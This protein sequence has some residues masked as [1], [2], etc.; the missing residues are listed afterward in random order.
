MDSLAKD[1]GVQ[2]S[3]LWLFFTDFLLFKR[4]FW[5]PVTAYQYRL[6]G[7]GKWEGARRAIFTQFDRM[8]KPLKTRQVWNIKWIFLVFLVL[9]HY[10]NLTKNCAKYTI[11]LS[12]ELKQEWSMSE[13]KQNINF[14]C[15]LQLDAQ[16]PSSSGRLM[17][18]CVTLVA[19]GAALYYIHVRN[20]ATIPTFLSKLR[21]QTVW[22]DSQAEAHLLPLS[23]EL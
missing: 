14:S 3:L 21:T 23:T 6:K 16:Q 2:P 7:P 11:P 4:L 10:A 9:L 22:T 17:K 19:G 20:P 8:Y 15:L 1:I 18:L 13:N 12:K 5:G